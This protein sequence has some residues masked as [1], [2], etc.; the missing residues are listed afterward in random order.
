MTEQDGAA[1]GQHEGGGAVSGHAGGHVERLH[2]LDHLRA[3]AMLMGVGLH[4]SISYM[5]YRMN[6]LWPAY[7][8]R[9]SMVFDVG[10][11]L[12]HGFRMQLFFLIA[13]YFARMLIHRLGARG[14][15]RH[16]LV[17]VGV[18]FVVGL[19]VLIGLQTWLMMWGFGVE[20]FAELKAFVVS[21]TDAEPTFPTAHLW[22]LEFL[23]IYYVVA[24]AVW[25]MGG[26]RLGEGVTGR[27]D[28]AMG[29]LMRS[30]WKVLVLA[31]PL[32]PLLMMGGLYGEVMSPGMDIVPDVA[33]VVYYGVFFGFGWLLQRRREWL[34]LV[35]RYG[36]WYLAAALPMFALYAYVLGHEMGGE[37]ETARWLWAAGLVA[38]A[39]YTWLMVFVFMGWFLRVF[40][41]H[42]E[43]A[44][45][46]ADA[47]YWFYLM[48]L[49]L[50]CFLQIYMVDW[51]VSVFVKFAVNMA[52]TF[53]VLLVSY[54]W[55]VRYT[56]I[57]R[58][59]NG[60]RVRPSDREGDG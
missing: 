6:V 40:S 47:S 59:L 10:I 49:P 22:F 17:R 50:V 28:A 27:V 43:R 39:C 41:G 52:V 34:D 35:P 46:M 48:H 8:E 12:I 36:W 54:E 24:V 31:V 5:V 2:A 25:V 55:L 32:V 45:Y 3:V 58:V 44:R 33:G 53:V 20:T 7:D 60:V 30:W 29:V 4:G 13:G 56:W 14:F 19:P 9:P 42:S 51:P 15:A 37:V 57:G 1:R 23:L 21:E 26:R 16:R 11:G 18:P 38:N